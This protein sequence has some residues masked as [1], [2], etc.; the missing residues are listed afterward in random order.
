MRNYG[1]GWNFGIIDHFFLYGEKEKVLESIYTTRP[2]FALHCLINFFKK[3]IFAVCFITGHIKLS[4]MSVPLQSND[5]AWKS[6]TVH[7]AYIW[8]S[9]TENDFSL[10]IVSGQWRYSEDCGSL[11][12]HW[13]KLLGPDLLHTHTQK[14]SSKSTT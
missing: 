5:I 1:P 3:D 14:V 7:H 13:A 4:D 8:I 6:F 12:C 2:E 11:I 9:K 10:D